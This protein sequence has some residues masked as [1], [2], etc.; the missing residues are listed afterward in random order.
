MSLPASSQHVRPASS[1]PQAI[2]PSARASDASGSAGGMETSEVT[3]LLE[4]LERGDRDALDRL[5]PLLY[6]ELRRIAGRV[7]AANPSDTLSPT[8]LVH[9][10]YLRLAGEDRGGWE[11][12]AHFL[13]VAA[14]AMRHIL[15]DRARERAAG[16]RG[17]GQRRVTLDEGVGAIA[18]QADTML[19]LDEALTQLAALDRRLAQVVECRFFGGMS[20]EETAVALGVTA[21]TVRR[22]W[23]KA[24]GLLHRALAG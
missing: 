6:P 15:V 19:E 10:L 5:V 14:V 20:E 16:K 24:R 17:G 11:S 22:D 18:E 2:G 12:R 13:A 1:D 8:A 9:E 7:H 4:R 21:R 3:A 23:V